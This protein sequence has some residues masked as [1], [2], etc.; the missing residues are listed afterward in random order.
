MSLFIVVER[1][2]REVRVWTIP[3]VKPQIPI[4]D[5]PHS[6]KAVDVTMSASVTLTFGGRIIYGLTSDA[7]R[8]WDQRLL[9]EHPPYVRDQDL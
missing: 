4:E 6:E 9:L 2:Q 1:K 8:K 5:L 3:V 7:T